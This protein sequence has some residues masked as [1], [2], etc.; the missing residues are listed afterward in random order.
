MTR[1][2]A[3]GA[4][5]GWRQRGVHPCRVTLPRMAMLL[6][7]LLLTGI[8]HAQPAD[9]VAYPVGPPVDIQLYVDLA[10]R[11]KAP[12]P[13]TVTAGI[14]L[15][16]VPAF[17][18]RCAPSPP[19][20]GDVLLGTEEPQD[21]LSGDATADILEGPRPDENRRGEVVVGP[22]WAVPSDHDRGRP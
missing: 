15:S 19:S 10:G 2:I 1:G 9:C 14:G 7:L 13:G 17:G 18:T 21:L 4:G 5:S 20:V 11:S 22:A 12:V 8:A 16:Q 3:S 6:M